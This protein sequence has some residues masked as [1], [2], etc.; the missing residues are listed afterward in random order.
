MAAILPGAHGCRGAPS[1]RIEP[2]GAHRRQSGLRVPRH[3]RT[4]L[5]SEGKR[6][7]VLAL[8]EVERYGR[9]SFGD[10]DY[11]SVYGLKPAE[12]HA[13]GVRLLARTAVECTRDRLADLIG[14]DIAAV[15]KSAPS[16]PGAVVVD[17]FAGSGNT[18]YW[19]TRH[20]PARRAVGFELDA[21]VFRAS[22]RNLSIVGSDVALLH[23]RHAAGLRALSV[24]EDLLLIVFI[25]PPW[26]DALSAGSGLDLRATKPPVAEI[27][28]L[29]AR[30]F[31]AHRVLLATQVHER[32][33]P[34]SLTELTS[35]CEWSLSETYAIDAP[36]RNHGLLLGTLGWTP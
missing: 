22:R 32:V 29:L 25:A 4:Y 20:V 30:T 11:V 23:E 16:G 14:R 13:R 26:G 12:W 8:W 31:P 1:R 17:P 5:L 6:N 9:D 21:A 28:Q 33:V 34:A 19:I 35:R 10:P 36:G 2:A 27:V 18:L 7:D 24:P 3:D 15:A